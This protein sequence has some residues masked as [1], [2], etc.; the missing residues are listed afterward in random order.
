MYIPVSARAIALPIL[1]PSGNSLA[2]PNGF[3]V[4]RSSHPACFS[5]P[6]MDM[7]CLS[8][9]TRARFSVGRRMTAS[10]PGPVPQ[11][12]LVHG[13]VQDPVEDRLHFVCDAAHGE[14]R[15]RA[16]VGNVP[17][18]PAAITNMAISLIMT[19]RPDMR[20][21]VM[22]C[23]QA[24]TLNKFRSKYRMTR[25]RSWPCRTMRLSIEMIR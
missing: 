5:S 20:G 14:D 3:K 4:N 11:P 19:C 15:C 9:V 6:G 2:G 8:A 22:V 21:M 13:H 17:E 7:V 16:Y 25:C 12:V 23:V 24:T 1:P 10:L 18:R